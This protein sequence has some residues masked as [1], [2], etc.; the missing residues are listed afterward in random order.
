MTSSVKTESEIE[1]MRVSGRMLATV[2]EVMREKA[3]PG[4]TPQDMSAFAKKELAR[5]GGEPAF[6]GF[7]GYPDIICIS[8]N[9]Q[10]QHSIPDNRP[11]QKR[12]R[13]EL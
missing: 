5:L 2:L 11:F 13:G 7:H 12:R 10:V 6:L 3:A 8:V 1:A 9:D 4:L